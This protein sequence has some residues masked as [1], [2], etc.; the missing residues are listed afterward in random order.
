MEVKHVCKILLVMHLIDLTGHLMFR[1]YTQP[2]VDRLTK[3]DSKDSQKKVLEDYLT[4]KSYF[5]STKENKL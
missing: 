2:V 4:Q 5:K 3:G 1:F